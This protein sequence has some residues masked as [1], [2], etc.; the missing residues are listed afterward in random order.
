MLAKKRRNISVEAFWQHILAAPMERD[1][2]NKC[3]KKAT[4]ND[5]NVHYTFD[6]SQTIGLP[7]HV[8]QMCPIFFASL[9]KVQVFGFRIDNVPLQL[10]FL[11]DENETIGKDGFNTHGP[12]A[13]KSMVD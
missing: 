10:D 12:N 4:G 1:T 11:V 5:V 7:H 3:I 8:R 9:Q 2:Y 13:V 6:F